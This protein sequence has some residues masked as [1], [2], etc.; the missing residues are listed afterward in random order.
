ML[1][2]S[3]QLG[4][5]HVPL[6]APVIAIVMEDLAV[7]GVTTIV[8]V[9]AAG[10]I[11]ADLEVGNV[12][13]CSSA[14]RDEGTSF[15]YS[16]D[17][18][19]ARPD[20][21]L[22]ERLRAALPEARF[23]PSWTTDAPYRETAE[24]VAAYQKEGLLTV[25]MEASA[26]FTVGACLG[27]QAASVFCVSDVLHGREWQPRFD[28]ADVDEGLWQLF[29]TVEAAVV[30]RQPTGDRSPATPHNCAGPWGVGPQSAEPR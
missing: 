11:G 16:A 20:S 26:M 29:Q 8:G 28:A 27:I 2:L 4:F 10:A 1:E 15:H 23:G 9:G 14:L 12:V 3:P 18:R 6:G 5:A 30:C 19:W 13:V 17:G 25:E 7:Q 22:T 21:D 24:E